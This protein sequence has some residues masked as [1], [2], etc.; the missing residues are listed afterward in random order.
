MIG[1]TQYCSTTSMVFSSFILVSCNAKI[2]YSL[3]NLKS[4]PAFKRVYYIKCTKHVLVF[5]L[6]WPEDSCRLLKFIMRFYLVSPESKILVGPASNGVGYLPPGGPEFEFK[7]S[8]PKTEWV[9]PRT[10]VTVAPLMNRLS[11]HCCL[12]KVDFFPCL[13]ICSCPSSLMKIHYPQPV[14]C[15]IPSTK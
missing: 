10:W 11:P 14:T 1:R 15:P 13:Y 8:L 2:F 4:I 12:D 7:N 5:V 6:S 9:N 3:Q